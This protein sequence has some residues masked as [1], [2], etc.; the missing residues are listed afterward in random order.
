MSSA[1]EPDARQLPQPNLMRRLYDWVLTLADHPSAPLALFIIAFAE[2]S[3]FP[4]PPD[5]LLLA[6]AIGAPHK[7]L[8]FAA[9]CT[10]GSVL[11]AM[12]GY[13]LGWG[14][15][16]T[17]D[18]FFYQYVPGFNEQVFN[19]LADSFSDNTF[20]AV[21][22]A[23][24]TPIPFKVFTVAAGA[25]LVPF[26]IFII[27][28]ISSRALRYFILA[29]LILWFGPAIKTWIDRYFNLL[30]IVATVLLVAG[31]AIIKYWV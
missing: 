5:V 8:R 3:F 13:A 6:M 16:G 15:W 26:G 31:F 22:A 1:P 28:A 19:R 20:A 27:G 12:A 2:A 18:A 9:I 30:T 23:G 29:S 21:F 11:G 14:L 7:A 24:F 4:I 25:A 17:L 10:V